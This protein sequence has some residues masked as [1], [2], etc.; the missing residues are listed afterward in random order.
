MT[1]MLSTCANYLS[2]NSV[3][4][5]NARVSVIRRSHITKKEKVLYQSILDT[6]KTRYSIKRLD[7]GLTLLI[8]F[9]CNVFVQSNF[10]AYKMLVTAGV[11]CKCVQQ[12]NTCL[13]HRIFYWFVRKNLGRVIEC[14]LISCFDYMWWPR[15]TLC[16]L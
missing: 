10:S 7:I 4:Y 13:F 15:L 8:Q 16:Q 6:G 9:T 11:L 2:N 3:K 14:W 5:D 12:S 1:G